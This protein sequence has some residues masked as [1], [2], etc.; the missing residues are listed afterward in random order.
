MALIRLKA[1]LKLILTFVAIVGLFGCAGTR[2]ADPAITKSHLDSS[3]YK[4]IAQRYIKDGKPSY[5][6]ESLLDTLEAAKAF[7]DAG[8][9]KDSRDAF[10]IAKDGLAWKADTVD[11]PAAV[12]NLVGTTL[13]S[14]AFGAYQGKIYE[15]GL[16]DY[17]QAI[18]SIMLGDEEGARVDF[19]RFD[20]RMSNAQMQFASYK[21]ELSKDQIKQAKDPAAATYQKSYAPIKTQID[22]GIADLSAQQKDSMIRNSAGQFMSGIF[23]ASSSAIQDKNRDKVLRPINDAK[24]AAATKQGADLSTKTATML[25]KNKFRSNGKVYV[26]YEDGTGPSFSE[27]RV[28]LPLFLVSNKV[29]YAG[30]AL[31]RFIPGKPAFGY[32]NVDKDQTAEMT[33]ISNI[34]GMDFRVAYPGIVTKAITSTIIKT[35]AQYVANSEID[36]KTKDNELVGSLLKIG[37]GAAQAATTKADTRAWVNLPNTIQV[38]VIDKPSTG[39]LTI[40]SS[41]GAMLLDV[42]LPASDNSLVLLK[43]SGVQGKPAVYVKALPAVNPI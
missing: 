41:S 6:K 17:Y 43:A 39:I 19:N 21:K 16:I 4:A 42:P 8:M 3:N 7:N 5:D 34:A 25:T 33:S 23:R 29:T 26:L 10:D 32:L 35:A 37:V 18:N 30:I 2:T 22:G 31:P 9:W 13:T 11:T 27:F 1:A 36:K 38:A 20:V 12:M 14:S 28:D 24:Q 15:G 40:K